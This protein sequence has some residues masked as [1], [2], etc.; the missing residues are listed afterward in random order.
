MKH[1]LLILLLGYLGL[2]NGQLALFGQNKAIPDT[3]LPYRVEMFPIADQ[4][5]LK[6]GIPYQSE[7]ELNQLLED[8]LS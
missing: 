8:F 2:Y 1:L 5:A 6:N 3:L 4:E 7:T